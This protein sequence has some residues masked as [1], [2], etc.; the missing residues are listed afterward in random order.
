MPV[1]RVRPVNLFD[2]WDP[3]R[4]ARADRTATGSSIGG[5]PTYFLTSLLDHPD[6]T[7]EHLRHFMHRRPRRLDGA[8]RGHRAAGR[9]RHQGVPLVRQHRAP[10][11]H[12]LAPH[13]PEDKRL[14]TDG[15]AAARRGDP[16][17]RRRR[18]LQPRPRLCLGYTDAALTAQAFDAD[19]W[20]RT[21]DVGVLDDD[22]YLTIT[23]RKSD[24]IIRGGEN[25]SALEV[26]EVLLG[27]PGVAEAVVVAAP[28]ER[29]GERAAAVLR[30]QAGH[31]MPTLDD[32]RAHFEAGGPGPPEVARGAA[33]GRR[34][35]AHRERQGAEVSGPRAAERHCQQPLHRSSENRILTR[36]KGVFHGSAVASGRHPVSAVR[37][38]Q[39]PV[40][41]AGGDDQVPAQGVQGRRPVRARSTAA[42][43][44]R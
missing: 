10:V 38:G 21:G 29:L 32:V 12:R 14:Y 40:R 13:A 31:D 28:D 37:R 26:E 6:F 36:G 34:L 18:D 43:R 3:G 20:Y 42:P 1:L 33:R 7:A 41:A 4:G 27:M 22:G 35:P 23:D 19:G 15:D 11:D 8:G 2:V 16:A 44:S 17:R 25:I 39:P 9:P 5:G 24:I 30:M